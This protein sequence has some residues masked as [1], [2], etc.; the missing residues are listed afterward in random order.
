M[1]SHKKNIAFK[2][3][4]EDEAMNNNDS[5]LLKKGRSEGYPPCTASTQTKKD[6][7]RPASQQQVLRLLL[8]VTACNYPSLIIGQ[9]FPQAGLPTITHPRDYQSISPSNKIGSGSG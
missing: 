2:G 7:S 4:D 8:P 5:N 3:K 9:S 1:P 6:I